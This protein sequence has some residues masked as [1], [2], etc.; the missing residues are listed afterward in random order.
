MAEPA[1]LNLET[2]VDGQVLPVPIEVA[3]MIGLI[4]GMIESLGY[5][6][7]IPVPDV[8]GAVFKKVIEYCNYHNENPSMEVE[9]PAD[10]AAEELKTVPVVV[11]PQNN[12]ENPEDEPENNAAPPAPEPVKPVK[13]VNKRFKKICDWDRQF[14][15]IDKN[16]LFDI[17]KAANCLDIKPLMAVACQTAAERIRQIGKTNTPKQAVIELR[18]FFGVENDFTPE[19]EE[20]N[21]K[22]AEWAMDI[23]D[24]DE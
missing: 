11:P 2:I 9:E 15:N 19:Q 7:V 20:Q 4:N 10:V 17:I 6:G 5:E 16:D 13:K 24:D 8:S 3:K 1:T 14:L 22:E 12:P 21:A 23:P 18:K